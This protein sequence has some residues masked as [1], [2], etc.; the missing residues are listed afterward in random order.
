MFSQ[1][2]AAGQQMHN[3]LIKSI[4]EIDITIGAAGTT[5]S[6]AVSGSKAFR[7]CILLPLGMKIAAG[8]TNDRRGWHAR[9]GYTVDGD[10]YITAITATTGT[11][12]S[13]V[14]RYVRAL[15]VEFMPWVLEVNDWN[16]YTMPVSEAS[17][18]VVTGDLCNDLGRSGLINLGVSVSGTISSTQN[19]SSTAGSI[20]FYPGT[21]YYYP[22]RGGSEGTMVFSFQNI[23]FAR[24]VVKQVGQLLGQILSG[25]SNEDT[26]LLNADGSGGNFV[27]NDNDPL[28][29][30]WGGW[31]H[32]GGFQDQH[33]LTYPSDAG[34]NGELICTT[35]R[36][37]S[38][39]QDGF[40]NHIVVQFNPKWVLQGTAQLSTIVMLGSDGEEGVNAYSGD[41]DKTIYWFQGSTTDN[42]FSNIDRFLP[43]LDMPD[44]TQVVGSRTVAASNIVY[45]QGSVL[46]FR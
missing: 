41:A 36:V 5:A 38:S 4:T 26:V 31:R 23:Q 13:G 8:A 21:A 37:G 35:E 10:G 1:F 19:V 34:T 11:T 24:G 16:E 9:L 44:S 17:A 33:M 32:T 3:T 45:V 22:R 7:N 30:L 20:E 29:F 43:S 39:S 12:D 27:A 40:Q 18:L 15:L 42:P 2:A 6:Q 14:E 28:L 25:T 46:E